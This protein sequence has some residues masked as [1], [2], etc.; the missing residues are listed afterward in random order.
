MLL[1]SG[2]KIDV[3]WTEVTKLEDSSKVA[4]NHCGVLISSKVERIK[5]HL[6]PSSSASHEH[7]FSTFGHVWSKQH[8]RL[9]RDKAEKLVKAYRYLHHHND[10]PDW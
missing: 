7:I 4:C 9:G 2:R 10:E 1:G 6:A 8:N 3:A 5:A